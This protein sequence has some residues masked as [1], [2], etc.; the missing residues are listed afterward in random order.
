MNEIHFV[1]TKLIRTYFRD[2]KDIN[3]EL[4]FSKQKDTN[5]S[6]LEL[7]FPLSLKE[8]IKSF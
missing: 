8:E 5:W 3:S 7:K 2:T 6:D 1:K 4:I